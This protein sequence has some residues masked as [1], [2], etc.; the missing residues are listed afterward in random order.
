MKGV[1]IYLAIFGCKETG[2]KCS[3]SCNNLI[4][5]ELAHSFRLLQQQLWYGSPFA[6]VPSGYGQPVVAILLNF[7]AAAPAYQ[8]TTR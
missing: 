3:T 6:L 2:G 7:T 5:Q 8:P 1:H 4:S